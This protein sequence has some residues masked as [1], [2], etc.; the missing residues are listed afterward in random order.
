[1]SGSLLVCDLAL[2]VFLARC[3]DPRG[4]CE[5]ADP[6][7][8]RIRTPAPRVAGAG[9][10]WHFLGSGDSDPSNQVGR[11]DEPADGL[12]SM[13]PVTQVAAVNLALASISSAA[14]NL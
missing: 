8:I 7:M 5:Q 3:C 9:N 10:V 12:G 4:A 6:S 14:Q 11:L 13:H 1:M 2:V